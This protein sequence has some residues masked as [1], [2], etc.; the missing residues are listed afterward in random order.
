MGAEDDRWTD[1]QKDRWQQREE[2]KNSSSSLKVYHQRNSE[3]PKGTQGS[4]HSLE[5]NR[6]QR[7]LDGKESNSQRGPRSLMTSD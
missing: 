4:E 2:K 1:R 3:E 5:K 7:R 6:L